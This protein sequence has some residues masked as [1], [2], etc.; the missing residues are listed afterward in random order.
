MSDALPVGLATARRDQIVPLN[1]RHP[2]DLDGNQTDVRSNA[3]GNEASPMLDKSQ[4]RALESVRTGYT[5]S[6]S[7]SIPAR[8]A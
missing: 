4:E 6:L 1:L 8:M 3:D 5:Q 7:S 2:R